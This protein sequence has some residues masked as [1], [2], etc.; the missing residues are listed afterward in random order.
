M[1]HPYMSTKLLTEGKSDNKTSPAYT[2]NLFVLMLGCMNYSKKQKITKQQTLEVQ[3]M[4]MM[5]IFHESRNR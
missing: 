4:R 3:T 2:L 5:D 1:H